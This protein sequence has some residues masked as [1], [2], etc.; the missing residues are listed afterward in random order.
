RIAVAETLDCT[1]HRFDAWVTALPTR[2]L[3]ALR[4]STPTGVLL[5][6]YGWVED[7]ARDVTTTREGGYIHAPSL[8]HA[9]TAGV[10]RSGYLTHNPEAAGSGALAVDLSSGRVRRALMLFDGVRQ[11]QP[12]G[13]LLG[14]AIERELH[15]A[16]L[17]RFTLSL[18]KLAPVLARRLT[19]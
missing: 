9:A 2:R 8:T 7:L 14:Y 10:L 12:L 13:A 3:A 15:Q 6:A 17:D 5:G 19:D 1:S 11:G 16:G 4:A 18:R